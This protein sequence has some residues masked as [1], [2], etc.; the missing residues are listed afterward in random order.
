[1]DRFDSKELENLCSGKSLRSVSS[2][3]L[4]AK[5]ARKSIALTNRRQRI[6]P[7][8]FVSLFTS[9]KTQECLICQ[10]KSYAEQGRKYALQ[11]DHNTLMK[12]TH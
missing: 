1:M 11:K 2:G 3:A 5:Y 7:R 4:R 12:N 6:I 10:Q 9:G 8:S